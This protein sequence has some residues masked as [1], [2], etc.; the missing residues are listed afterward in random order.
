MRE[1]TGS[2]L[3]STPP[4]RLPSGDLGSLAVFA[5]RLAR[6]LRSEPRWLRGVH[7]RLVGMIGLIVLITSG[8]G[9]KTLAD[10]P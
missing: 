5:E 6:A 7:W 9:A 4:A 10:P 1:A 2:A 8:P 3:R